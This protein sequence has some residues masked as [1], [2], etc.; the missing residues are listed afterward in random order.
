MKS[1]TKVAHK[2]DPPSADGKK[3]VLPDT[4]HLWGHGGN[5]KW[6]WKCFLRGL[7]PIFMDPWN[8]MAGIEDEKKT[9]GWI[10]DEGGI[11]KDDRN[12][13][14]FFLIRQNMGHTRSFAQRIMQVLPPTQTCTNS[15]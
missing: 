2:F 6:V 1:S 3:V 8:P 11:T 7:N 9:T 13:P 5:Y 10:Y 14:E 4:D 12:Y 15:F